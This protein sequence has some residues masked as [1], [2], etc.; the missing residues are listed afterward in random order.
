MI[1]VFSLSFIYR[2][3]VSVI[4]AAVTQLWEN[5]KKF[6]KVT[7]MFIGESQPYIWS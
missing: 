3:I 7:K 2:A 4:C 1:L 5:T 6:A